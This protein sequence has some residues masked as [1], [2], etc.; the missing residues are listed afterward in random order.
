ML[1][2]PSKDRD[3]IRINW[4]DQCLVYKV[5]TNFIKVKSLADN[6]ET[7]PPNI[8]AVV[9]ALCYTQPFSYTDCGLSTSVTHLHFAPSQ[10]AEG[11]GETERDREKEGGRRE[12]G[13][14]QKREIGSF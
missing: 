7:K 1:I 9:V 14:K 2:S 4:K 3:Q 6:N 13:K 8:S 11:R 12:E 10:L 5:N